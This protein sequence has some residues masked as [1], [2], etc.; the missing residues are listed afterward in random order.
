MKKISC[1]AAAIGYWIMPIDLIPD[2]AVVVAGIGYA[3]DVV[4]SILFLIIALRR[5]K[6]EK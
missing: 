4:V 3:D 6:G 1:L 5:E 2:P